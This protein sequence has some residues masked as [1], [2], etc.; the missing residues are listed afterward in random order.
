M[1]HGRTVPLIV[2]SALVLASLS[3]CAPPGELLAGAAPAQALSWEERGA[4]ELLAMRENAQTF[5]AEFSGAA[6]EAYDGGKNFAVSPISVYAALAMAAEC[7]NGQTKTQLLGVLHA[8]ET[9]LQDGFG[10]LYRSLEH[11]SE[12]EKIILSNSVWIAE[13][14]AFRQPCLD[15]L[16]SDFYC[17]SYAADFGGNNEA[18]NEAIQNFVKEQTNGLIDQ[19][20]G[21]STGTRFALINTLYLKTNWNAE[22]DDLTE[23]DK[24]YAFANADGSTTQTRLMYAPY[25]IGEVYETEEFSTFYATTNMGCRVKFLLPHDGYTAQEIFT[26]ENIALA[27]TLSDYGGRT[28]EG[29]ICSTRCLFPAF[30]AE[31]NKDVSS[32]LMALGVND[33]FTSACDLSAALD[34]DAYCEKIQHVTKLKVEKKG[35]EGAAATVADMGTESE[36]GYGTI[37]YDFV[38]DRAFAYIITDPYGTTLFAGVVN[39]I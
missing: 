12:K 16:A 8:S 15:M 21:L 19:N 5:A 7:A 30:E 2:G 22:G 33:L 38:I 28:E 27:T 32:L 3:A 26:Q 24:T 6:G 17:S 10:L 11:D 23:T 9:Q 18:A 20:F 14:A 29:T 39:K 4:G 37:R 25:A 1:K 34:E 31:Y 36:D 13:D 35:I